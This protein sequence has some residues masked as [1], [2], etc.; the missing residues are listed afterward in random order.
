MKF[1]GLAIPLVSQGISYKDVKKLT[2]PDDSLSLKDILERFVR[3]EP[4]SVGME[5]NYDPEAE[6]DDAED[7][8]KLRH[9]DLVDREEY[10]NKLKAK[11]RLFRK[12]EE[13]EK[14]R[15]KAEKLA[16][17][18]AAKEKEKTE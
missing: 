2:V 6:N 16:A 5:V 8:E 10:I 17:E 12:Q 1:K 18:R 3:G 14:M 15:L 7:I 11:E 9:M 13:E 4:V